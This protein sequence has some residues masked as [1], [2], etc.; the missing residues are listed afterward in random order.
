MINKLKNNNISS[1]YIQIGMRISKIRNEMGMN[2]S[3]LSDK[4]GISVEKI[5]NMEDG[6]SKITM[7]ILIKIANV[8][9]CDVNYF[10]TGL[11]NSMIRDKLEILTKYIDVFKFVNKLPSVQRDALLEMF[12]DVNEK[13]NKTE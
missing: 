3:E 10:L 1:P 12:Y 6:K 7:D 13:Q 8:L 11:S 5:K 2:I 4:V 9:D